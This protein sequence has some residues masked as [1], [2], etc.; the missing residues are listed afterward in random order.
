MFHLGKK[1]PSPRLWT[2]RSP[3]V[4]RMQRA[5]LH[6]LSKALLAR[7]DRGAPCV[8]ARRRGPGDPT[9]VDTERGGAAQKVLR[10][11]RREAHAAAARRV[12]HCQRERVQQQPAR[13]GRGAV[14]RV[15]GDGVAER[16]GV[17]ADLV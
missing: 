2:S 9:L 14:L 15:A 11:Q 12:R 17:H 3:L 16:R 7:D 8:T 10:R 13:L 1:P 5:T 6:L 4:S